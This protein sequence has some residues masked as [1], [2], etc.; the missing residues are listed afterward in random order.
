MMGRTPGDLAQMIAKQT[1]LKEWQ[2]MVMD[3]STFDPA[4][5]RFIVVYILAA[6]NKRSMQY[7]RE[8]REKL[9]EIAGEKAP[10]LLVLDQEAIKPEQVQPLFGPAPVDWGETIW[11][12]DGQI[13]A[14]FPRTADPEACELFL[15]QLM[16]QE[17]DGAEGS[18]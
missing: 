7:L 5:Y 14:R 4:R 6:W 15:R 13:L 3:P 11:I 17:E 12:A 8:L 9:D 18:L 2:V 10:S 1:G 16:G